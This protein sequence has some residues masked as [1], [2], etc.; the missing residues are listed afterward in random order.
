MRN[1]KNYQAIESTI[2][3]RDSVS[4]TNDNG[5]RFTLLCRL[6]DISFGNTFFKHKDLKTKP[7]DFLLIITQRRKLNIFSPVIAVVDGIHY[8]KI[9]EFIEV[10]IVAVITSCS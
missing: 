1:F 5:E 8:C 9:L 10:L 7:H 2:G 3:P 4:I 6:N